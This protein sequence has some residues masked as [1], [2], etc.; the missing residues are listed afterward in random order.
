MLQLRQRQVLAKSQRHP[1]LFFSLT[2]IHG[3]DGGYVL[4]FC[5]DFF[6]G[7]NLMKDFGVS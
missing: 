7:K 3:G 4:G 6:L 2:K 1:W 5:L